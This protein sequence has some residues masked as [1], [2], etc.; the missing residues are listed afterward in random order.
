MNTVDKIVMFTISFIASL[1]YFYVN[2]KPGVIETKMDL[3]WF[4]IGF[5][6]PYIVFVIIINKKR[7][8][9]DING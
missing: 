8:V 2:Y 9:V 7:K 4:I 6:T 1:F 3:I 5:V